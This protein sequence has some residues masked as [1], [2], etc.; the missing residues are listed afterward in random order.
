MFCFLFNTLLDT[1]TTCRGGG[2]PSLKL[3]LR[4]NSAVQCYWGESEGGLMSQRVFR[5][6]FK[7]RFW[8]TCFWWGGGCW[9]RYAFY[10]LFWTSSRLI[11]VAPLHSSTA[12]VC[13]KWR[14]Y[15]LWRLTGSW[16]NILIDFLST[17][18]VWLSPY[19]PGSGLRG[20]SL[21]RSSSPDA[22]RGAS[23]NNWLSQAPRIK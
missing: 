8:F 21:T 16:Y 17:C 19:P 6:I 7:E 3:L 1:P 2:G 23:F 10:V 13:R 20:S 18:G 12:A 4:S 9:S 14:G 22:E 11:I 15:V 5:C